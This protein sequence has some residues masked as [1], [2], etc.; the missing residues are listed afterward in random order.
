[1]AKEVNQSR[2]KLDN[3]IAT[4]EALQVEEMAE[5]SELLE[6]RKKTK[7]MLQESAVLDDEESVQPFS[8][9]EGGFMEM[10]RESNLSMRH[11]RFCCSG[12]VVIF[13]L[14][15]S[16]F[17]GWKGV[18]YLLDRPSKEIVQ[19]RPD[20]VEEPGV[21]LDALDASIQSGQ[22]LGEDDF[23]PDTATEAGENIGKQRLV[24]DEFARL[25]DD[26]S[27]LYNA[28]QV[29]VPRML[30]QSRNRAASLEQYQT[31]LNHLLFVGRQNVAQL[32]V[33][34]DTLLE[35]FS[36]VEDEKDLLEVQFFEEMRNLD[37]NG[38]VGAL[39]QFIV[40]GQEVVELRADYLARQKLQYFYQIVM[41]DMEIRILDI[42]LNE[43]ALVKGVK[44]VNISGS[45]INL[46][47]DESEL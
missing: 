38:S 35:K 19:E 25:M 22:L 16:I 27:D 42:N 2:E 41:E 1:L 47:I 30:D 31:E 9:D 3:K 28:M 7:S 5:S 37:S 21:N 12:V 46:I 4:P 15:A 8:E 10:L 20:E 6:R 43:E 33:E 44:V 32:E 29:D 36:A 26:F 18:Q 17:G 39:N 45:D 24:D 40:Q 13:L 11:L 14:I 34:S 23:E